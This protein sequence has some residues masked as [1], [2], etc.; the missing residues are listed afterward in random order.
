MQKLLF[1]EQ[2]TEESQLF[3]EAV[4]VMGVLQDGGLPL[5]K[6]AA[7]YKSTAMQKLALAQEIDWNCVLE[8]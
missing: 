5:Y 7:P 2:E 4:I 1:D 3:A 8:P 6:N